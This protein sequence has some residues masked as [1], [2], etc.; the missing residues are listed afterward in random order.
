MLLFAT[1]LAIIL[2][3]VQFSNE[4]IVNT[5]GKYYTHVLSFSA[6]ISITYVFIDLFPNFSIN[7][8]E[9]N[10]FIFVTILIGFI[11]IHLVENTVFLADLL[12]KNKITTNLLEVEEKAVAESRTSNEIKWRSLK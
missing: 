10:Q 3:L 8:V 2:G 9:T 6:G 5:C 12:K 4:Q 1:I 7:A 11:F